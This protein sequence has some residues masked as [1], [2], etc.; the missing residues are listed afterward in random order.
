MSAMFNLLGVTLLQTEPMTAARVPGGAAVLGSFVNDLKELLR[1][2]YD[3]VIESGSRTLCV[4]VAPEGRLQAWLTATDDEPCDDEQ[5]AFQRACRDMA[6]PRVVDGPI[7]VAL[8]FSL[9]SE[10]PAES[11]LTFPDD[12]RAILRASDTTL[13]VEQIITRFWAS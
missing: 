7:A 3:D 5:A 12:W 11:Q 9:G 13:S 4:A 10:P 2:Q 8:V 6:V 1:E